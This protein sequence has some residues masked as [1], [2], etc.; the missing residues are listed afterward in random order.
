ITCQNGF[1]VLQLPYKLQKQTVTRSENDNPF[2]DDD[3]FDDSARRFSMYIVLP[4]RWD[5]LE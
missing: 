2:D 4:D 5:G 3:M 1:K